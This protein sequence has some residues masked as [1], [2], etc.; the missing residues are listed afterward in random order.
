MQKVELTFLLAVDVARESFAV[1]PS[2]HC[3]E[4]GKIFSVIKNFLEQIFGKSALSS[5]NQ[6]EV[7]RFGRLP[8]FL[9]FCSKKWE[10]A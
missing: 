2:L 6:W 9:A 3:G 10:V 8:D 4:N 7:A 1:L 5:V